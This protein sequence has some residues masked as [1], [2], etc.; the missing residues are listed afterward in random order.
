MKKKI[1]RVFLIILILFILYCVWN[2]TIIKKHENA[3]YNFR[4]TDN[5]YFSR[6][7]A[8][9]DGNT[10]EIFYKDGKG[11]MVARNDAE[12]FWSQYGEDKNSAQIMVIDSRK[13][14]VV[15]ESP[16]GVGLNGNIPYN[17]TFFLIDP[18]YSDEITT[19]EKILS[20]FMYAICPVIPTEYNGVKCYEI[21]YGM[22][23]V[24][25]AKI[26]IDR[27]TL[28]PVA[29]VEVINNDNTET[30]E[31]KLDIVTD[32]DVTMPD[33]SEYTQSI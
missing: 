25:I 7:Y 10:V 33:L 5:H 23:L 24:R 14:F 16:Y 11:K 26:Y 29:S 31:C 9:E 27:E 6:H 21:N 4:M 15:F 3:L 18:H 1:V 12:T 28:L 20:Y 8:T 2:F 13:E 22:G 19:K 17:Y 30:Y 32:E